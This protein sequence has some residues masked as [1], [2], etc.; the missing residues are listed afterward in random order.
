M[1]GLVFAELVMFYPVL[2]V[3]P[4][5]DICYFFKYSSMLARLPN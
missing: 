4:E 2:E 5:P 3:A 1:E